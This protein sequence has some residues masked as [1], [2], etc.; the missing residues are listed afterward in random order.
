MQKNECSE[1]KN[2]TDWG[3]ERY[4]PLYPTIVSGDIVDPNPVV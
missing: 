4:R 3:A 1:C 2:V